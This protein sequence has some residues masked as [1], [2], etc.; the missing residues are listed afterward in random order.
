VAAIIDDGGATK[1]AEDY[2]KWLAKK[3]LEGA[4]LL[5]PAGCAPPPEP[6]PILSVAGYLERLE[7]ERGGKG[8][9]LAIDAV[10]QL[11]NQTEE[12]RR[13]YPQYPKFSVPPPFKYYYGDPGT[14][15]AGLGQY[16]K[17][18]I[19]FLFIFGHART[20]ETH[21][22]GEP[23]IVYV[24]G[25]PDFLIVEACM[26]YMKPPAKVRLS[27]C[28]QKNARWEQLSRDGV[29]FGCSPAFE[30]QISD[31]RN[32]F[33]EMLNMHTYIIDGKEVGP[34]W[35]EPKQARLEG[36]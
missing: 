34:E 7:D 4:A 3:A 2:F 1:K 26:P 32:G 10:N 20:D 9:E 24:G 21:D 17:S 35:K 29:E 27:G 30:Q 28:L 12:L 36:G 33:I 31:L 5:I 15:R 22:K 23:D 14:L 25:I 18:S 13:K 8:A 19:T 6:E 11:R 16:D